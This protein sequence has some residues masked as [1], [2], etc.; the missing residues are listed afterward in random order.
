MNER[1]SALLVRLGADPALRARFVEDAG[2]VM[3][4]AGLSP[5]ERAELVRHVDAEGRPHAESIVPSE[6][7]VEEAEGRIFAPEGRIHAP[8]SAGDAPLDAP[9]GRIHAAE[10]GEDEPL[11]APEGRIFAPGD[12]PAGDPFSDE[13]QE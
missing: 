3:A 10:S 8:E 7:P 4:E 2:S 13:G 9:E 1:I 11:G 6:E 12:E 5:I